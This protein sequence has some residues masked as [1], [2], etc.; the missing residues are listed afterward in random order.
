MLSGPL[1]HCDLLLTPVIR[2]R[3]PYAEAVSATQGTALDA[4]IGELSALTRTISMLGFPALV[5]PMGADPNGLPIAL[6]L[7]GSPLSE[8]LLLR[9][10]H[11]FELATEWTRR[12]P[13]L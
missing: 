3:V 7:I 8:A 11:A 1:A 4:V 13:L 10:G 12:R 2:T 9:V 5:T 6:Q